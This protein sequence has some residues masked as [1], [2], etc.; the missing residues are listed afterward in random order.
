MLGAR[1]TYRMAD[2][3]TKLV[4]SADSATAKAIIRYVLTPAIVVLCGISTMYL[5]GLADKVDGAA[6]RTE[7]KETATTLKSESDRANAALWTAIGNTTKAQ[8]E[9]TTSIAVLQSQVASA[10]QSFADESTYV[11]NTLSDIQNRLAG[12]PSRTPN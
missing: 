12:R 2:L 1:R 6:A 8:S 10:R 5:R 4:E 3:G 11:R 9:L 7:V